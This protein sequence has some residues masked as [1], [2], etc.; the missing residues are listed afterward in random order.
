MD[1]KEV[2]V[3]VRRKFELKLSTDE[4]VGLANGEPWATNV[5]HE[6]MTQTLSHGV[7]EAK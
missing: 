1:L 2:T 5:L 3:P 7:E 6:F 4:L